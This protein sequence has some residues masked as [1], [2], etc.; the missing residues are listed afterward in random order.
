VIDREKSLENDSSPLKIEPFQIII[1]PLKAP[2]EGIN[3]N[4]LNF[5]GQKFFK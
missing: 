2:T 3:S 4:L 1:R 5:L